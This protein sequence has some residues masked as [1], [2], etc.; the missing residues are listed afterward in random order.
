MKYVYLLTESSLVKVGVLRK[1]FRFPRD[2]YNG[3]NGGID[4]AKGF[5]HTRLLG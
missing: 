5:L 4:D 1:I 3:V 2:P